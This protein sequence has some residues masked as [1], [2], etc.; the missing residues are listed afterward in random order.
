MNANDQP[1]GDR[2]SDRG[3]D[4]V[5][6][7]EASR[8]NAK[9]RTEPHLQ[10]TSPKEAHGPAARDAARYE[11]EVPVPTNHGARGDQSVNR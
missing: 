10:G 11:Q 6:D 9:E 1:R 7:T 8:R 2:N 5:A 3:N 4:R